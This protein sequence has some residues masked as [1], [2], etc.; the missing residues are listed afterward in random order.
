MDQI[1]FENRLY[2]GRRKYAVL[3][4]PEPYIKSVIINSSQRKEN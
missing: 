3:K 2:I 4:L 1:P